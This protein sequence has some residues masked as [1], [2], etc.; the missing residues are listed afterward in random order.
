MLGYSSRTVKI[1]NINI[2]VVGG[3]YVGKAT[4]LLECEGVDVSIYDVDP[5]KCSSGISRIEDLSSCHLIFVCVPTPMS[6]H[7]QCD[8]SIVES[9]I[10]ELKEKL[11]DNC[12]PIIIR[13]TVPVGFCKDN[14]V[15]FM[16]EFLTEKHWE[17]DF[18]KN[19]DWIV[20]TFDSANLDFKERIRA[21]F[22][23]A[24]NEGKLKNNP[25]IHFV[26]SEVAEV[27]KYA[28]NCFLATKVSFF[29]EV[30]EFCEAKN[31][32]Y[33]L[34]KE[35]VSLDTRIGDSHMSVPGHDGKKGF[36]GT[37]FPKDM[38]SLSMQMIEVNVDPILISAAT[39]RNVNK[40]RPEK[41][42]ES[43]KGRAVSF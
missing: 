28:R 32:D 30:A 25:M 43:D 41:D 7:G 11:A 18:L 16:P 15:N 4:A 1:R 26:P 19:E 2:G 29:N 35:F 27:C 38:A 6:K 24:Y 42:W 10:K 21:L 39:N 23:L 14:G 33:D 22:I 8:T 37:C 36:G 12:P 34:V 17:N 9:V 20:G 5:E 31:V 3:G 40:D 13:S